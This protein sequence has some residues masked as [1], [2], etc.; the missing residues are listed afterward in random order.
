MSTYVDTTKSIGDQL[1]DGLKQF[2]ERSVSTLASI[3]EFATKYMPEMPDMQ[4]PEFPSFG[5]FPSASE[6]V[7]ANF[8][9]FERVMKAQKDV[10]LS[11]IDAVPAPAAAAPAPKRKAASKS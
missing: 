5:E 8:A 7:A 2:E 11:L 9:L 6:V 10:L 1:V 4:L 3:S